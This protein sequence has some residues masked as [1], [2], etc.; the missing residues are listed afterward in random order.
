LG[1]N[2]L[3]SSKRLAFTIVMPRAAS[4]GERLSTGEPHPG[5][6]QRSK[7]VPLSPT[8]LKMLTGPLNRT[9]PIGTSAISEKA[10]PDVFWQFTQ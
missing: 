2:Q 1:C 7:P 5:Q 6:K 4:C 9:F 8:S 3:V 10:E